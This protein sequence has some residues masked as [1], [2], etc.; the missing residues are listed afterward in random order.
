MKKLADILRAQ[1]E[2]LGVSQQT[3]AEHIGVSRQTVKQWEDGRTTPGRKRSALVAK[4]YQLPLGAIDPLAISSIKQ[5]DSV[6][7]VHTIPVV[8]LDALIDKKGGTRALRDVSRESGAGMLAVAD[9]LQHCFAV[10]VAD[11]SMEPE[12]R[13]GDTCVVDPNVDPSDGDRVIVG[14][15][16]NVALLRAYHSRGRDKDGCVVFDLTTPNPN[17]STVTVNSQSGGQLSGVVIE[18]RRKLR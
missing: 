13:E 4:A 2:K 1:R 12:F 10:L 14:F 11:E 16:N 6:S 17:Y 18:H 15:P 3:V 5:I 7:E 9:G 8:R